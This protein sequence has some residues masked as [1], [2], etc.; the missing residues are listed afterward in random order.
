MGNFWRRKVTAARSLRTMNCWP[1]SATRVRPTQFCQK[2]LATAGTSEM[3]LWYWQSSSKLLYI[4]FEFKRNE[5]HLVTA[6]RCVTG[7]DRSNP[8][9]FIFYSS[10]KRNLGNFECLCHF[11]CYDSLTKIYF[12]KRF[13]LCIVQS[14]SKIHFQKCIHSHWI[15]LSCASLYCDPSEHVLSWK[16]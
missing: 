16:D 1:T 14:L 7:A 6:Q 12:E 4:S 11:A 3:C 2:R 9:Y 5:E 13:F 8:I 15:T 10:F